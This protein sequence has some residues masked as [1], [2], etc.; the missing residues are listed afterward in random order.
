[1]RDNNSYRSVFERKTAV[2][3]AATMLLIN[4][5]G[6]LFYPSTVW[7]GEK[8]ADNLGNNTVPQV[9]SDEE[10]IT[11]EGTINDVFGEVRFNSGSIG[12]VKNTGKVSENKNDEKINR[13]FVPLPPTTMEQFITM[14]S[15][16]ALKTP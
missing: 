11:N 4:M 16:K 1:M 12:D 2:W 13:N 10:M 7:A 8:I 3:M 5:A 9:N 15:V 14:G 6:A